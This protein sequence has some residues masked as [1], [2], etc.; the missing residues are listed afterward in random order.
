M[1]EHVFRTARLG[2]RRLVDAD[3]PALRAVF[4]DPYAAQFY[5]GM[6]EPDG[7]ARWI[8]WNLKNYDDHGFGLWA[9]EWLETGRLVGDARITHQ[10]VDG[11]RIL[12]IGWHVHPS[13]RAMGLATEAGLACLAYG[14]EQLR[15]DTLGSI[16][17]P[18]NV[19]S[20]RVASRVH[21][22]RRDARGK[23]GAILLFTTSAA[24]FA[25]RA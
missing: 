2:L 5:P 11:E 25:A 20:I 12:E 22:Q 4:A 13:F 24:E 23:N 17:D 19:A 6:S 1:K 7:P 8:A 16:V 3:A 9:L 10:L 18:A 15:A 14:F 21:A